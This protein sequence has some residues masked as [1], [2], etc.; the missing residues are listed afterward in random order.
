MFVAPAA[1]SG[2]FWTPRVDPRPS[3][4]KI[5]MIL[6]FGGDKLAALLPPPIPEPF[7]ALLG[8][9]PTIVGRMFPLF[10]LLATIVLFDLW[11][12]LAALLPPP[13]P[14][15]FAALLGPAPT[16]VGQMFPSFEFVATIV[17]FDLYWL[18]CGCFWAKM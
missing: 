8:P 14:E 7:A 13:I 6:G 4:L 10:K 11:D 1:P 3:P 12:K 17:L 16:I 15:P 2:P 5:Q 9:A 18:V